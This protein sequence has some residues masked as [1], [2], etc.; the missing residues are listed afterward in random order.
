MEIKNEHE[1]QETLTL[2]LLYVQEVVAAARKESDNTTACS[3]HPQIHAS[4]SNGARVR[5]GGRYT[6]V[7]SMISLI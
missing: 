7:P 4:S 2:T 1:F 5:N 3:R 6:L